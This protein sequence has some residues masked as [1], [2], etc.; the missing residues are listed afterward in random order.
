MVWVTIALSGDGVLSS[1]LSP[2][3]LRI[4][5]FDFLSDIFSLRVSLKVMIVVWTLVTLTVSSVMV[6]LRVVS[7]VVMVVIFVFKVVIAVVRVAMVS[8]DLLRIPC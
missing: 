5:F 6:V 3:D 7:W 1:A 8:F 4:S 2:Y